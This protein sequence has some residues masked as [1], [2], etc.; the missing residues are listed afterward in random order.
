MHS[1]AQVNLF[2]KSNRIFSYKGRFKKQPFLRN[3]ISVIGLSREGENKIFIF[4]S[5][6]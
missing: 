2:A 6:S 3:D 4:T 5:S 1:W